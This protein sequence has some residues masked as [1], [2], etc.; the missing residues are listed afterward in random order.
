MGF[1][2]MS[3]KFCPNCNFKNG[4][5][6]K[7]CQ[8]CGS[9]LDLTDYIE[10]KKLDKTF[11]QKVK[12]FFG[13]KRIDE[14]NKEI[15]E[16]INLS[17]DL[18]DYYDDL[19]NLTSLKLNKTEF[20][21]KYSKISKLDDFKYLDEINEDEDLNKKLLSLKTI[22][23]FINNFDEEIEKLNKL[24]KDIDLKIKDIDIFNDDLNELLTSDEK[25]D[26]SDKNTLIQVHKNT[27]DFFD[28]D[29]VKNLNIDS[30]NKIHEFLDKYQTIDALFEK[31]NEEIEIKEHNRLISNSV[32]KAEEY[33]QKINDFKESEEFI[34]SATAIEIK[35]DFKQYY[36]ILS[37]EDNGFLDLSIQSKSNI[38]KFLRDYPKTEEI[39]EK[40]NEDLSIRILQNKIDSNVETLNQFNTDFNYLLDSDFYITFKQKDE[41]IE[42]YADLFDLVKEANE[43]IELSDQFKEFLKTYPEIESLIESRNEKYVQDELEEHEEFFDDIDGKSLDS[44]Q[45]L[46]V[47][48]NELNS[49]IIAGA[50]CGKTLTV[51]AKV[52]YLIEKKGINP[53]DILC[54]SFS[55]L[56]VRDLKE[57]LPEGIE[58]ATFHK[59]GGKILRE[60]NQISR[61]DGDA[62]DNFI[63]I[64]FRDNI[65][66]NEKLCKDFFEF[67]S[68]YTYDNIE[69]EDA[70]SLGEV[71]DIEEARDFT[72][73]REI[74]GGENEK[75]TFKNETV[76]SFEEL[77]IANY[78]FAH[79]IDYV[80]E[81]VYETD[82]KNFLQHKMFIFDL[83][84]SEFDEIEPYLEIVDVLVN[85]LCSV[86]E[87]EEHV[88]LDEYKPDFYL[89]ENDIYLEHFG[90]NRNCQARW[91]N[92]EKSKEYSDGI[93]WKRCLHRTY[94]SKLLETYSYY[95][96]EDRLLLRL[97]EK[98]KKQG[99][100]IRDI[101]YEYMLSKI[102]ERSD[103]NKF[104]D[105]M[106][107]IK[108]FIEL[109]K[110]NDYTID[111][112]NEFREINKSNPRIFDR[113]RS[114]LFL[115]VVEDIY[116][117][118]Q[119]Y[120]AE[121][122]KIDFNDMI[123]NATRE[124]EKGHL[125]SK[126]KY[127]L[128]DEYQDTSYTRYNLVKAIQN[129]TGAKVCV[130]GD[131][132]QS[133]YRF[134][135]CDVSLFTKFEDYFENPEKLRIETTYRN[136]QELI[137][138]S[139][140]FIRKNTN[141][142][143]K[144]LKSKKEPTEKPVKI[145]YYNK[146]SLE[147]KIKA[148]EYLVEKIS[149]ISNEIMILGR[150]NFDINAFI[151]DRKLHDNNLEIRP[152][153]QAKDGK[154][155]Y[156]KNEDLEIEYITVHRSKGLENDN[157][158]LINLENSRSG[159]PNQIEDD[160]IMDFVINDSDQYEFGEERRLFYVALTRT[161]NNV[162]L[163]VPETDKSSFVI[164]LEENIDDLEIL[165]KDDG[166]SE[167]LDNPEEFMKDKKL[168]SII[169]PLKCPVCE[170]G[171]VSLILLNK[172]S[173]SLI[174][175]F[176]CSHEKCDWDGGFYSS[177]LELLDEIE[178]CP[179]CGGV[180]QVRN[181]RYGPFYSCSNRCKTPK[182]TGEKLERVNKIIQEMEA[183][184][185]FETHESNLDCPKC[186]EGKVV[187]KINP[188][189]K[190]KSF[191]CSNET[192]DW[193]GG[194]TKI[195]A[196]DL[197]KI[198]ICP[199]CGGVLTLKNSR[200]GKFYG[201]SNFP[202]CR[203]TKDEN[204]AAEDKKVVKGIKTKLKCP[205]CNDGDVTLKGKKFVCTNCDWDG[206]TFSG[207]TS[208]LDS[209][210]YCENPNCTG[211]TFLRDGKFGEFRSCSNYFKTKCR[212]KG[213]SEPKKTYSKKEKSV[214]KWEKFDTELTCP[215]CN[216]GDVILLRNK[217]TERGF[218]KCTNDNCDWNGGSFNKSVDLLD[219][220]SYCPEDDCEGLTYEI[221]GKYG[222]F[223]VCTYFAKTKCK[224]GRKK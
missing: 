126:Y 72:T 111:K 138:I 210:E 17:Y 122:H 5:E 66:N 93:K 169:T 45:R 4:N 153:K 189:N 170:T 116:I 19:T 133:I 91:L 213:K 119:N 109:F 14:I 128:V 184:I 6:D 202:K 101:D 53:V 42:C 64:Y 152:F 147:D 48:K 172:G 206:G 26:V 200:R 221:E 113:R 7:F 141:Q 219:T 69:E 49:Q 160:S 83:L 211:V 88:L 183:N 120:L 80:Y 142:L 81:K 145:I 103:V 118:Y 178:I 174:K 124:V 25:L 68:Y 18:K 125:K 161:K 137:D 148:M 186:G 149:K 123:N 217:E 107:L 12:S 76:K 132:W 156:K 86:F 168:H 121:I 78:L 214:S 56:S 187:L 31:H 58:V 2:F 162:Y 165:K 192:C 195:D 39:I 32:E 65:I 23:T 97:E 16:F 180:M 63:K 95:M 87:V 150:N 84:F 55:N 37:E 205:V 105:L 52:R 135:G 130:V 9:T 112:F 100:E 139:G 92:E 134:T 38:S 175:F 136:S 22:K 35:N 108:N 154:L 67:Y 193:D 199:D 177:D 33:I 198:Q 30:K 181:G 90:V 209:L 115:N 51:N 173:K 215:S 146:K 85:D 144:Q 166:L 164:E 29:K 216:T 129:K 75:T 27:Y 207:D 159:F 201:C 114:E 70:D 79:Q 15:D 110:G 171:D 106:K 167:S 117:S 82:N 77:V 188:E 204:D 185:E 71:Y 151:D 127:I 62:L 157:V 60:N 208:K 222:P 220:L 46:A 218:F 143:D 74:Y 190:N 163:L 182:L 212:G 191:G 57:S 41:L 11:A 50:G 59:L 223:R 73:L 3:E 197:D 224:A 102:V 10:S 13:N 44:N 34:P 140:S 40:I 61:P 96:S 43:K 131:D 20:K 104:K 54:L 179:E 21:E 24:I 94:G 194:K 158:I 28:R 1:Y 155:I 47:V 203:F 176:S 36:D 98:L 99:I 89:V 8:E 196:D